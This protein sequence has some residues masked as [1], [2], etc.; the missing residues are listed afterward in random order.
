MWTFLF[1]IVFKYN[2]KSVINNISDLFA[3]LRSDG[4]LNTGDSKAGEIAY[5]I[6]LV[7]PVRLRSDVLL[8]RRRLIWK[9]NKL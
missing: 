2:N 3:Y 5:N 7:F 6:S 4:I 8:V 1:Q 9:K